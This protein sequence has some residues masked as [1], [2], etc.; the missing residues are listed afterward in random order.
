LPGLVGGPVHGHAAGLPDEFPHQDLLV[1]DGPQA[2]S[3]RQAA[4]HKVTPWRW[5]DWVGVIKITSFV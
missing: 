1:V 2:A 4:R 3:A 5:V